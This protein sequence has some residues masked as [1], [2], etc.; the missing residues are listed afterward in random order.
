MGDLTPTALDTEISGLDS[1]SVITVAGL[2]LDLGSW[3]ALNTTWR[4]TD[5]DRLEAELEYASGSNVRVAVYHSE[6]DLLRGLDAFASDHLDD[7]HH[8]LTAFSGEM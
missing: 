3:L 2:T 7:D 4:D 8:Y 5:A 1:G 6:A